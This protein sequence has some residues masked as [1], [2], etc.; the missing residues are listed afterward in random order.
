MDWVLYFFPKTGNSPPAEAALDSL[1][2]TIITKLKEKEVNIVSCLPSTLFN[3]CIIQM[4]QKTRSFF[5]V[6]ENILW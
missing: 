4:P 2:P 6:Q 5:E 1:K 3:T